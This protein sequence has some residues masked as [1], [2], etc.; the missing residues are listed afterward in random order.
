MASSV[1]RPTD[2]GSAVGMGGEGIP[3]PPPA[4]PSVGGILNHP[5]ASPATG[6]SGTVP[7]DSKAATSPA[8][9]R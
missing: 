9:G 6:T 8:S 4:P 5:A 3:L 2:P 7:L 1:T